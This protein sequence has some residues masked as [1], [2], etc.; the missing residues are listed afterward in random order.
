MAGTGGQQKQQC[1]NDDKPQPK[2][3]CGKNQHLNNAGKCVPDSN[4]LNPDVVK[5]KPARSSAGRMK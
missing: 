3:V 1:V 4:S 2:P 5:P